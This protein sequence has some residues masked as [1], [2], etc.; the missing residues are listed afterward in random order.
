MSD[1]LDY[2]NDL[3]ISYAHIDN[4]GFTEIEKGW[5]DLLHEA[6]NWRLPQLMGGPVKIWRDR[7]LGGNDVFTETILI[8]LANS[9][10][11]ITVNSPRNL[12]SLSCRDELDGIFV[13]PDQTAGL[14]IG[15]KHRV[16]KVVKNYV[17][18]EK[19]TQ[20]LLDMLVY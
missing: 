7:K 4:A 10:I 19:H 16:L 5:I 15:D 6:L 17:H 18:L 12:Q 1:K 3:F 13:A 8:E 11:L 2:K 14:R 20:E 9:A